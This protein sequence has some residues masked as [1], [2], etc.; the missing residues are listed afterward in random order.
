ML[1]V[2]FTNNLLKKSK[3]IGAGSFTLTSLLTKKWR[4][5]EVLPS[6]ALVIFSDTSLK[7]YKD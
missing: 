7:K 4:A 6:M 1:R 2:F 5:I 3:K